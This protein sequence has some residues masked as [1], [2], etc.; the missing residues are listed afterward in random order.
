MRS[1]TPAYGRT[2]ELPVPALHGGLVAGAFAWLAN[3]ASYFLRVFDATMDDG[4]LAPLKN[5]PESGYELFR[6]SAAVGATLSQARARLGQSLTVVLSTSGARARGPVSFDRADTSSGALVVLPGTV[7][8]AG[9]T[10]REYVLT[11]ALV[12]GALDAG[13]H[14]G[15]VEALDVGAAYDCPGPFSRTTTEVVEG[16]ID[17]IVQLSTALSTTDSTFVF[18]PFMRCAQAGD[19]TGGA[20]GVLDGLAEDAGTARRPNE[21]DDLLRFRIRSLPDTVS[22]AALRRALAAVFEALRVQTQLAE[23]GELSF[24]TCWDAPLAA[25]PLVPEYDPTRFVFDDPRF[26]RFPWG[27]RW[28]DSVEERGAAYAV[29]PPMPVLADL[30]GHFDAGDLGSGDRQSSVGVYYPF[31]WL[32]DGDDPSG[33]TPWDGDDYALSATYRAAYDAL[34]SA[35]AGGVFVTLELL[36]E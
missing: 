33:L 21:S 15:I 9:K 2:Y 10:G 8:R 19:V 32:D 20:D 5:T 30:T 22:P 17:T 6:A 27:N 24:Q 4:Y 12:F 34:A 13:P 31:A 18:D 1:S 26:D 36:G 35:R 7:V 14:I 25:N 29:L 23:V 3:D 28:V 11:E 16:A